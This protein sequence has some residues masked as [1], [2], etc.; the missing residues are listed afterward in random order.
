LT[1]DIGAAIQSTQ[2]VIVPAQSEIV[3]EIEPSQVAVAA[4]GGIIPALVDVIIEGQRAKNAENLIQPVRDSLADFDL[5]KHISESLNQDMRR[6]GWLHVQDI[7]VHYDKTPD[8]VKTLLASSPHD[9]FVVV[10]PAYF[11]TQDFT[12]LRME[13]LL[14]IYSKA[15]TV[16][17][18]STGSVST[19]GHQAIYH[20]KAEFRFVLPNA[21]VH[22]GVLRGKEIAAQQWVK[23]GGK[24]IREAVKEGADNLATQLIKELEDPYSMVSSPVAFAR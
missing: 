14:D 2:V 1:A 12:T 7:T 10:Q 17:P 16:V 19:K 22:P 3:A 4:G 13:A 8:L 6:L 24:P 18:S 21:L 5:G 9:T 11:L 23:S 20:D 15:H